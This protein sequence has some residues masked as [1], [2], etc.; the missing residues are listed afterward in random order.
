MGG[1]GEG[2]AAVVAAAGT[3]CGCRLGSARPA[4]GAPS[5]RMPWRACPP[6]TR[7]LMSLHGSGH[8][9][10]VIVIDEGQRPLQ[11]WV[12]LQGLAA[13]MLQQLLHQRRRQLGHQEPP[14]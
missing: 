12:L 5:R 4:L 11:L 7:L 13:L 3:P 6:V 14:H 9:D 8:A 2:L 10:D 1:G